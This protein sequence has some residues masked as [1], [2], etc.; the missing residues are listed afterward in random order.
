MKLVQSDGPVH[1]SMIEL[2]QQLVNNQTNSSPMS[3]NNLPDKIF[4]TANGT[5]S[6]ELIFKNETVLTLDENDRL[7]NVIEIQDEQ[8]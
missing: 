2:G 3:R 4:L 1:D 6:S 8:D 7:I 5:A